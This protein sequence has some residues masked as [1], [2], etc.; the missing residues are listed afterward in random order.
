MSIM[1]SLILIFLQGFVLGASVLY[2][3]FSPKAYNIINVFI[4]LAASI[5]T[6]IYS[7]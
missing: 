7:V 6:I 3:M 4:V 5:V 1:T 2:A